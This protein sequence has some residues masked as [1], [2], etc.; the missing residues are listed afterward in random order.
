MVK[1]KLDRRT[2]WTYLDSFGYRLELVFSQGLE[3]LGD[4]FFRL[5]LVVEILERLDDGLSP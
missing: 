3:S 4:H 5:Y 1:K 2:N